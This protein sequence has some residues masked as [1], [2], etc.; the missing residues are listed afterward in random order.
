MIGNV[1]LEVGGEMTTISSV[2]PFDSLDDF[3]YLGGNV[4]HDADLPIEI[5]RRIATPVVAF[6]ST[7]SN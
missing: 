1:C 2:V 6:G 5:D 4:N 7:P 3:V